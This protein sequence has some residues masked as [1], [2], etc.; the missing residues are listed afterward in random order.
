MFVFKVS[1]VHPSITARCAWIAAGWSPLQLVGDGQVMEASQG[2]RAMQAPV[3]T[4]LGINLCK[5]KQEGA[6]KSSDR[7]AKA[8][9]RKLHMQPAHVLLLCL[10]GFSPVAPVSSHSLGKYAH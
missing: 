3:R 2:Q 1:A 9:F 4:Q 5:G 8:C 10:R 7:N 6:E